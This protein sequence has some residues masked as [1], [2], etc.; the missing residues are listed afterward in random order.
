MDSHPFDVR[1]IADA[2][3]AGWFG[4]ADQSILLHDLG[5]L[6]EHVAE[7]HQHFPRGALLIAIKANP[8]IR[9]RTV[10]ASGAGLGA[11][12]IEEVPSTSGR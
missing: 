4:A 9:T 6:D 12:S 8:V 1:P 7:L 11:A 5:L 10:V 3:E 2:I